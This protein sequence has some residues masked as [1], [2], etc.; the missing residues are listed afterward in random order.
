[1]FCHSEHPLPS[2]HLGIGVV[3]EDMDEAAEQA[4]LSF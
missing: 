4:S 1:M 3:V 2:D